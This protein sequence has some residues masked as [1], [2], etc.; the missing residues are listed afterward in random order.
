MLGAIEDMNKFIY[1]PRLLSA[2]CQLPLLS[3]SNDAHFF[4][5]ISG[6][7]MH[8]VLE[9][10]KE[11]KNPCKLSFL[12]RRRG[13]VSSHLNARALNANLRLPVFFGGKNVFVFFC[14]GVKG[15]SSLL[16]YHE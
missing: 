9:R 5:H 2:D 14:L 15:F 11:R 10:R 8:H 12:C 1:D 13:K 16:L 6:A 4:P 3:I 7:K